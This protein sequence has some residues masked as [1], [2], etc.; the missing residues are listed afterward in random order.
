MSMQ[1][2]DLGAPLRTRQEVIIDRLRN[3]ILRGDLRPGQ[4]LDQNELAVALKVSRSP[5]REALRT[6]SAEGLVEVIPHRGAI[7]AELSA[8]ELEEILT[9]RGVLE[10]MA[11]RLAVPKMTDEQIKTLGIL[12]DK[13]N[14]TT[15]PDQ[16]VELNHH[17]HQTIYQAANRPRLLSLIVNL[18][19]TITPYMRQYIASSEHIRN[20]ALSHQTIYD[21]CVKRDPILVE[22]ET[23]KHLAAAS[24]GIVVYAKAPGA[25]PAN[26]L[27]LVSSLPTDSSVESSW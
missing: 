19:N 3:A 23:Q 8:D 17:F 14:H 1:S 12:L 4:K 20:V 6:L 9:L 22:Q 13:I 27:N 18:R 24:P 7:V 15:D 21:A 2:I 10:G 25:A 5:I 16:W 11:A 26:N